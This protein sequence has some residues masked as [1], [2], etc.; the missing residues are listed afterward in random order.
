VQVSYSGT[1]AFKNVKTP[2][3][4][5]DSSQVSSKIRFSSR[6]CYSCLVYT[7]TEI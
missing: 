1:Q 6:L 2:A 3:S 4:N 5:T 7:T